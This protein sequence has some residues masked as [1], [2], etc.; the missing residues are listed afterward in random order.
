MKPR[1]QSHSRYPIR[2]SE[3]KSEPK[4][5]YQ[6]QPEE[7]KESEQPQYR[8]PRPSSWGVP[9]EPSLVSEWRRPAKKETSSKLKNMIN[10]FII[11]Q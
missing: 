11:E 2:Y 6:Y 8:S 9:Q 7:E 10:R 3:P 4:Y 1:Y 5:K